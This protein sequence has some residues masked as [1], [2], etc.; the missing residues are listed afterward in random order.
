MGV[1]N[2]AIHWTA[3]A[4]FVWFGAS[5]AL[6]NLLAFSLAV[7]FSF[8]ANAR[9]TFEAR[10]TLTRYLL[11]VGFMGALATLTG[12]AAD[13]AHL[14]PLVTLVGFSAISLVCGYAYSRF[15]VFK[16]SK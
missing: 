7:T 12:W 3:F 14:H 4:L 9:W 8:F 11:Y 16:V 13:R 2:T 5:Q 10:S 6:A 15:V 1:V